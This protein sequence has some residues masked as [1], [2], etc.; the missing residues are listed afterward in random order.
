MSISKNKFQILKNLLTTKFFFMYN[1]NINK[2]HL[3]VNEYATK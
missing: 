2:L 3:E 1:P